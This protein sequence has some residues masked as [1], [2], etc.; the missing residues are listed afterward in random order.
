[1]ASTNYVDFNPPP[2]VAAWLNDVN[3]ITYNLLGNGVTIPANRVALMQNLGA[4]SIA[5]LADLATTTKGAGYVGYGLGVAYGAGTLGRSFQRAPT[6]VGKLVTT[7]RSNTVAVV[8]DPELILPIGLPGTYAFKAWLPVAAGAGAI[9]IGPS[10]AGVILNQ[11][12]FYFGRINSASVLAD[13]NAS[14]GTINTPLAVAGTD[15]IMIEGYFQTSSTLGNLS[16]QWAQNAA[17]AAPTSLFQGAY[18]SAMR[19]A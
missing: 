9:K 2:V 6:S 13:V 5:D 16:I 8:D 4:V 7:T 19:T 11:N 14:F 12:M 1:M 15:W 3:T 10:F 18:L 17:N